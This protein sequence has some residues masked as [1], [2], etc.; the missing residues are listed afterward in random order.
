MVFFNRDYRHNFRKGS[1][2]PEKKKNKYLEL[3]KSLKV[4]NEYQVI[5]SIP[6]EKH[7]L[8]YYET[9]GFFN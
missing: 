5:P 8:G 4:Q 3:L 1:L 7:K 6:G 2:S 9:P